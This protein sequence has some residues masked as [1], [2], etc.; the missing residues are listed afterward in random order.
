MGGWSLV[1]PQLCSGIEAV[2]T[3]RASI[4]LTPQIAASSRSEHWEIFHK[5]LPVK[6]GKSLL[7]WAPPVAKLCKPEMESTSTGTAEVSLS[8]QHSFSEL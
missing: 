4:Y 5:V 6:M 1:I 8:R 2:P 7:V 3:S